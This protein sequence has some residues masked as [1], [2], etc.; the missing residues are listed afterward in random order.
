MSKID[1]FS[2]KNIKDD[3]FIN[4]RIISSLFIQL[5]LK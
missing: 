5:I 1:Y 4:M 2:N 3:K